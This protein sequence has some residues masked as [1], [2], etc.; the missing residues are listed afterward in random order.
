NA[1]S[2]VILISNRGHGD[3]ENEINHLGMMHYFDVVSGA[4]EVTL[5]KSHL[6]PSQMPEDL[7]KRLINSLNGSDEE[8]LRATLSE[9]A[10]YAHPD[11]T[12]IGRIDKKPDSTRLAESL[13]RLSVQP[14][15][16][17]T[18]YG[19]QPSDIKQLKSVAEPKSRVL[20][21]V[22]VNAQRDDVGREIDVDG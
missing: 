7:Q 21:G 22:I 8:A 2:R 15:V 9:A 16:P 18:S 19:D 10:I 17:I 13:E 20:K 11:S 12:T 6:P 4:E 5:E 14:N 3:L 1:N